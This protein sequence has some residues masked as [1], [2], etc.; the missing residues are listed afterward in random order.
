[1]FVHW[2]DMEAAES[3]KLIQSSMGCQLE[4]FP[5]VNTWI[6]KSIRPFYWGLL[7]SRLPGQFPL[8][9]PQF[10][11][12]FSNRKQLSV[13]QL[14]IK[15]FVVPDFFVP[16]RCCPNRVHCNLERTKK[17]QIFVHI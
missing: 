13:I 16:F 2:E 6:Q 7:P 14:V 9:Q 15:H 5:P 8:V 10:F 12:H 11:C 1:M 3:Q 4:L 17:R